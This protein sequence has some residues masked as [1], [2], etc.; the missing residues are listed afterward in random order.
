[1][2]LED[3]ARKREFERTPEPGP[4]MSV[5]AADGHKIFC[6]QRHAAR[7][8]HYDL[9]LEIGGALKSWAIPQGPTQDPSI[10]RLAVHVEDHPLLYATFEGNIPKGNYGAGSMMLWD[11]GTFEVLGDMPAE[12][13]LARG[14]F[15][16]RLHGQKAQG[17]FALVRIKSSQAN[18]WLLLKKKDAAAQAGWDIEQFAHS[19]ATGRTQDEIA[20][21]LPARTP[22]AMP[23][24]LTP[25][26]AS[27]GPIPRGE[28]WVYEIK[29]DGVRALCYVRDGQVKLIGRRGTHY[30]RQYPELNDLAKH[31]KTPTAILDGEICALDEQ[32]RPNFEKLQPRIMASGTTAIARMARSN[33]VVFFAFDLLYAGGQDLRDLPLLERKERLRALLEVTPHLRYSEHFHSGVDDLLAAAKAQGLEGVVAKHGDSRYTGDRTRDWVKLKIRLE[34]EFVICGRMA[35][36]RPP[37]GSLLL[38]IWDGGQL[39]FA[40]TV[41][42]GFDGPLL[43]KLA[44]RLQPLEVTTSPFAE[45]LTFPREVVFARPEL[46]ATIAY[47]EFTSDGRLRAPVFVRLREDVNPSECVRVDTAEAVTREPLLP[48]AKPEVSLSV[49]SHRVKFT[50][51][52]KI[53]YP[54]DGI[55]KREFI[56]Y[57]AAVADFLL[58]HL[59]DR[60]LSLRR[61][62]DGIAQPGFFQKN[63]AE[64]FPTW[65]RTAT[66]VAE[67]HEE[68][69]QIIG[70]GRA[71]LLYLANLG[72]IDQNP[73]MSR[74]ATLDHPDFILIDLDPYECPYAKIVEAA[75]LIR[76]KLDLLELTGYPKTTGGHGLHIYVP[77]EPIYSYEQSRGIAEVL[78]RLV[79]VERPD[80]FTLP[81]AVGKREPGKVYFD[82]LQNA[83]GKTISA[84]YVPRAHAGATVAT[85]LEWREIKASLQPSQFHIRNAMERFARTGDLFAGVLQ[86]PQR[87]ETAFEKL[88][89]LL[90]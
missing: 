68:R 15:K 45:K 23:D 69:Q 31:V 46:V 21:D 56:N 37:F 53:Y 12:G 33:P 29:W 11:A 43:K 76:R 10:K 64:G 17:E 49:D 84:P 20:A 8:L 2:G 88:Q 41:G 9:R 70:G 25:M 28:P 47:H 34:Q 16:F 66:I 51:L 18:E 62:P 83:R 32:G 79:A 6:I 27:P 40:G 55:D 59:A 24:G 19:V 87:L 71:D 73:W 58:P 61:Y 72:C 90:R 44:A 78:A 65:I 75:L 60:P 1:M 42:S 63:A 30:D 77:L 36:E 82:Y 35:G 80:L 5:P 38:G 54:A 86:Q 48:L 39:R 26:L 7:R 22:T 89:Q 57:Y 50:N 74:L 52:H 85:P 13:Q 67:H 14:D 81:R 4:Q 3:Y